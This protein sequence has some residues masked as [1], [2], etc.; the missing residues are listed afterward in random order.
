[1]SISKFSNAFIFASNTLQDIIL[2]QRHWFYIRRVLSIWFKTKEIQNRYSQIVMKLKCSYILLEDHSF[3][4]LFNIKLSKWG[5]KSSKVIKHSMQPAFTMPHGHSITRCA[6]EN[7]KGMYKQAIMFLFTVWT[8]IIALF[9]YLAIYY[10]HAQTIRHEL[11][12]L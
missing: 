12:N 7:H 6:I 2:I 4:S 3:T 1:M 10:K 5:P 8:E 9:L 11:I